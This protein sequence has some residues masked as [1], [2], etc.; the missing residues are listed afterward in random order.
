MLVS[1]K[2][3]PEGRKSPAENDAWHF[4]QIAAGI[5]ASRPELSYGSKVLWSVIRVTIIFKK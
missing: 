4:G 1:S 2:D 3:A 5:R